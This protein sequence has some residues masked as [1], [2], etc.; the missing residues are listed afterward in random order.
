MVLVLPIVVHTRV[1][2]VCCLFVFI[3]RARVTF[4]VVTVVVVARTLR[5]GS[6]VQLKFVCN[7]FHSP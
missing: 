7:G 2:K 3:L 1:C 6:R 5:T 4:L